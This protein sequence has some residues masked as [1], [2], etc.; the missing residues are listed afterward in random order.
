MISNH[1]EKPKIGNV[2]YAQGVAGLFERGAELERIAANLARAAG[3]EGRLVVVEGPAG[4][5][6]SQLLAEARRQAESPARQP[7]LLVLSAR[8]SELE[9]EFAFGV[10]RQLFEAE[11]ARRG[12]GPLAGPAAPAGA[13]FGQVDAST[14]VPSFAVLHGLFWLTVNL[15]HDSPL[16]TCG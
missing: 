3:G 2:L 11:L 4:I 9:E 12:N 8:G 1:T 13:V 7:P 5:G 10:V 16:L 14:A 6:K 15:A